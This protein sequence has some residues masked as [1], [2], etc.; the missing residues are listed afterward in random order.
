MKAGHRQFDFLHLT[1]NTY[2]NS[3]LKILL[4]R[5]GFEEPAVLKKE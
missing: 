2:A 4:S 3:A 5:Y 1:T